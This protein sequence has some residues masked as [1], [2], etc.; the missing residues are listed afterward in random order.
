MQVE[1]HPYAY[2]DF[3]GRI[4]EGEYGAGLVEK[5]GWRNLRSRR[6]A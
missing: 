4:P 2:K 5:M 6:R 1:D 3:E